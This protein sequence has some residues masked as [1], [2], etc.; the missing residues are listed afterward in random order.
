MADEIDWLDLPGR[1]TYGVDRGGR[2]FFINDEEKSTSWVHPGTESPIQSGHS[3]SPGLPKGWEMDST[4]EGAVYFINHNER[5]NTFLHPLTGQVPEEN[6]KFDLKTSALDMSNKAGGKRPATNNSDLSNHNMV[7]EVPPE[8]PSVRATRTSRKAIAFG[9]R[10]HSMKRNPN[11]PVTKAGWLSKQAS[12][13]VKQWNKRWFVL[14]DRC[15]F[16][17]KDEKEESVLGSIP[18]LSFRVAAVQPSDNISRKHTFKVTVCWLDEAGASSTHCLSPQAEHAGVRT[19]FFSAESP[20]EQEA[21][22]QAM[23]EAARVQIP[24]AQKSVP[25]AARHN[26]PTTTQLHAGL[27]SLTTSPLA[28]RSHEKPD[29]ENIPPSKHHHQPPHNSLPKSEPEAKTRGEGDGRGC[30]KAERRPERPEVKSEPLVKANGVHTGPG[31]GSEPGS[32][33]P[34]GPRVPGGGERPTQPNGWQYSSPSRPGSTA[35]PPQDSESGGHRQSFPPRVNPDKI[36]QRKSSM[37]QLQQWVNLR[38]GVPP[39]EDLRSPSRFYPVSRRVPEYYNPYSS[40]YPDDYQH[41]PP[42][43][44]PDS[45]CSMPAYD[46]ISPPWA[47]EDKRHSFRNGGGPAFQLREWKE[48]AGYGRQD[49]TVWIP[50]PSRQP[51][52]YDELDAAS[53]SLRRLSLQPRSHSVPRSPSQGSYSRARIY[54][55][56]RSPSARFERLPPR[57]EDIYADPAA[58]VM[59]RSISSPKYDYLGDRR[60]VPAGLFPYNYPPS[61]TV[62]D[63]MDELLDLQLQRNLEYLDQQMSESETL[64]SMVNHM[65]ENSSPRA[66]LFMQVP[67]YPEVFRDSLHTYKLNE[68][69]TDKLLGKLCEQNKVVREQDR[70]V[71]QLRAEKESLESALMGTH[72][73]LEMFGSQPAYPE[74]LLHKK[75]S[76]QNQLINIRVELSQA[77]TALA[78]STVEYEGLESEVSALHDELWEQ[79]SLDLQN[80]V[81][82]RQIQKEIWRIQDVME[83]LRKNNPSRGT[84]TAKHRGGLGPSATYSSNSP[85][86]PLSSAS[87]TSPLS[88]FSLVSGS[89]GSPTKPGSSEPK[90]SY[91]PSKKDPHQTSP[92][93]TTKDISLVPTRQEVEAEKQAALNKVGIV[94]PRTKSPSDE[95]VT[96]SRVVRRTTNMLT[97]GLSSRQERPKSAV[98][99]GEGKVKMSVEEQID[100]MRRHQSGSM[101]DKRRS[102]QLPASPAPD[103][104]TRP[105]YK[106][107]RRH[108]SIHEVDISNLE[109]ALR[110]EEPGGQAYETPREEI[111]RLRKMELEPQHYDVDISKELS[112]PDKVLIPERYIDLEPDTPLSPE[113]LKEKQ[114]K[115][116]RIKTLIAKSSMQNVVPIG[117]GDLVDVPQD[118]ESQLQEQEKR[119]EISCALATEASRRGRMLS[120]QCATPS[121]PT[122]PASPAPPANPLS[123]ESPRGADSSHA[124]RV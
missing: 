119:I 9:K 32:P 24:P 48:P 47:L 35:F 88:P 36:A 80:E 114:K 16:Y 89:Q 70:L 104:S 84:D 69:D 51:V 75:E 105:A 2:V 112:T 82:S 10:S 18:L 50:S 31:P 63:K 12:S 92:L 39:P 123:S 33:Y 106:V 5:R 79:L 65:V 11:A 29:S 3:S 20:E 27:E 15:L 22:I 34:E 116:E 46:R 41:Y 103:P 73:E 26:L 100:R 6:K 121:P 110:A 62:H 67:P 56:V 17:Y 90:A 54:S 42:G 98:F 124:M 61:P 57:S 74:K 4:Q 113:E 7:S 49:G 71:Q 117:E 115:V 13:G 99:P 107:V 102:L 37:N 55:P 28:S 25:Q 44:R 87:L 122:S 96:P 78:N 120:V 45:I 109:A 95:E 19:Y 83:G 97:N 93:D 85:A 108:R 38:R 94:P 111:A 21:W 118:S 52:Y 91:E 43:V 86:S 58:Y 68:Q 101:K 60:P 64:I 72:Q 8:R 76:L 53:G 66:Q 30:E 40:Q 77:T 23:G 1:W 14:V 81:L 59:R